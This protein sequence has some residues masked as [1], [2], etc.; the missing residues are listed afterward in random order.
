MRPG[1]KKKRVVGFAV[2][3]RNLNLLLLLGFPSVYF[4]SFE[5]M[6]FVLSNSFEWIGILDLKPYWLQP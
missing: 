2:G 6:C 3:D 1:V 4:K 5:K